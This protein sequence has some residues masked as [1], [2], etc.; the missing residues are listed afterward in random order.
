MPPEPVRVTRR[1]E[2][3]QA[4]SP[5]LISFSRPIKLVSWTGR[6]L[7]WVMVVT[8]GGKSCGRPDGAAW[9]RCSGLPSLSVDAPP[10]L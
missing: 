1:L 3:Q 9:K 2:V 6:L 4:T 7:G 5:R 10:D 8:R